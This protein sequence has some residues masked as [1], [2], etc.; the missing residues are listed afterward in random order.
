MTHAVYVSRSRA[1]LGWPRAHLLIRRA[2]CAALDSEGVG[3]PC[4]VNVMLTNDAGIREIN[5]AHRGIDSATDVLSFPMSEQIPGCFAAPACEINP[6]T[7]R[8]LLGDIVLSLERAESQG[9]EYGHGF[10]RELG[11]LTV[12]SALHLL[13]YDH[14]DEGPMKRLMRER[15]EAVMSGLRLD[16]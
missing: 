16:V 10:D 12:H 9:E 11:Y 14:V 7:G 15:E 6:G 1:G 3:R 13:G 4:E 8:L 2:V 5:R